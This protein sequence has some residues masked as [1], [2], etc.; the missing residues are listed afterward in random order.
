MENK[1][2]NLTITF[3]KILE[4]CACS[5]GQLIMTSSGRM[6]SKTLCA[7]RLEKKRIL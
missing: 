1:D 2:N 7:Y 6:A 4:K 3:Y 5:V